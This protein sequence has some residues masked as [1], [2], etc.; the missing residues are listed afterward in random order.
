MLTGVIKELEGQDVAMCNIPNAFVQT[1]LNQHDS[2][3]H[4]TN[5]KIR[6]SLVDILI[7]MDSK[8]EKFVVTR[9]N[10]CQLTFSFFGRFNR[11]LQSRSF[12]VIHKTKWL[13]QVRYMAFVPKISPY[14]TINQK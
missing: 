2:D 3:G 1:E 6:G 9:D 12:K 14:L 7:V 8:N 4:R 10:L 13:D 11:Q 5:M